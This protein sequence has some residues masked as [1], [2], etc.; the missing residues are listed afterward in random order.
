MI[1][2]TLRNKAERARFAM[3]HGS[4]LKEAAQR[5]GLTPAQL[6]QLLWKTIG[7]KS[8]GHYDRLVREVG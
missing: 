4:D 8:E 1:H 2:D 3:K 5:V 7:G 6:D